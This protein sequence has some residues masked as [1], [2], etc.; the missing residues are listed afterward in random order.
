MND[1]AQRI[2]EALCT[3]QDLEEQNK[4]LQEQLAF[5]K[6]EFV[7]YCQKIETQAAVILNENDFLRKKNHQ[8]EHKLGI[9]QRACAGMQA[10][11]QSAKATGIAAL[12]EML[13][14]CT[15]ELYAGARQPSKGSPELTVQPPP[16][17]LQQGNGTAH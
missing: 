7:D 9:F 14:Q 4:A 6:R 2:A 17:F 8:L 15:V 13:R 10:A 3:V 11:A 12:D 16:K 5:A 1:R